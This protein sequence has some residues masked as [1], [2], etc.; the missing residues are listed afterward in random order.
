MF[1]LGP[2]RPRQLPRTGLMAARLEP[3]LENIVPHRLSP[4]QGPWTTLDYAVFLGSAYPG[5]AHA[6]SKQVALWKPTTV[7]LSRAT[8]HCPNYPRALWK[9]TSVALPRAIIHITEE[10]TL[11]LSLCESELDLSRFREKWLV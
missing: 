10:W 4:R 9:P 6:G 3:N 7:T 8:L 1:G 2:V 11:S 5:I